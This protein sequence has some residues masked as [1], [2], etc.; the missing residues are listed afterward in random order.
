MYIPQKKMRKFMCL[1]S[2]FFIQLFYADGK[3]FLV[4]SWR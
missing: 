2:A 3:A 1:I 4:V